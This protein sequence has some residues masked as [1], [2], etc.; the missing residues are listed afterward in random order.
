[1]SLDRG[2]LKLVGLDVFWDIFGIYLRE[3]IVKM[4]FIFVIDVIGFI[5]DDIE[6]VKIVIKNILY[7]VKDFNFVLRNY[8]LVIFLD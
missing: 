1:M 4:L 8:V 3:E 5:S 2:F 7:E 6:K